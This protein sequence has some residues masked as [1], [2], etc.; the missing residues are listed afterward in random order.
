MWKRQVSV[1]P[2]VGAACGVADFAARADEDRLVA[3]AGLLDARDL[4]AGE[5][6]FRIHQF[7]GAGHDHV[8]GTVT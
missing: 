1:P 6:V 3:V 4:R 8:A 7:A 5:H 2:T